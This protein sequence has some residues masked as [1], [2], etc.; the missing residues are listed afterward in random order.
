MHF[1]ATAVLVLVAWVVLALP[2]AMFVGRFLRAGTG[3][4]EEASRSRRR[5]SFRRIA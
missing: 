5:G 4:P 3:L 1:L 2:V